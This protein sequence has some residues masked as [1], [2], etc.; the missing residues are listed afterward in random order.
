MSKRKEKFAKSLS[1]FLKPKGVTTL[2][3][4][5]LEVDTA[6]VCNWKSGKSFPEAET[7]IKIAEFFNCSVDAILGRE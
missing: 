1:M 4:N 7:V 3:A 5:Y 2:L 6:A